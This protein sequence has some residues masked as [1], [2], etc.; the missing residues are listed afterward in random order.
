MSAWDSTYFSVFNLWFTLRVS[1]SAEAPECPIVLCSRLWKIVCQLVQVVNSL[2]GRQSFFQWLVILQ[3]S[4]Q[5][6]GSSVSQNIGN[7]FKWFSCA[8]LFRASTHLH[9]SAHHPILTVLWFFEVL[10][11][12]AHHAKSLRSES[13]SRSAELHSFD[14]SN[15]LWAPHHQVKTGGL[16]KSM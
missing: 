16:S 2:I 13:E 11:V 4:A 1:A 6:H 8:E 12:T 3:C 9:T 5:S 7:V 10:H 14:C 15:A